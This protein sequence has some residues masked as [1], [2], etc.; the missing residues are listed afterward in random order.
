MNFDEIYEK[1]FVR[2]Y[3][4]VRMKTMNDEQAEDITAKVFE[5]IYRNI[6]RYSE[7]KGNMDTWIFS[8]TRNEIATFYRN[9]KVQTVCI[10]SVGEVVDTSENPEQIL[11]RKIKN[12][13]LV[14]SIY[15]LNENERIAVGLKYGSGL[16]N[17]D[18]GEIMGIS[19][20]NVGVI[21]F[22]SM[23]KLKKEMK[24]YEGK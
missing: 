19:A 2:V 21:L 9:N 12:K 13:E 3:R 6:S 17:K 5:S 7:E 16:K 14:E 10:D 18:I 23:K 1:Y 4:F 11:D 20:S 8:I 24:S 15:K 22:R